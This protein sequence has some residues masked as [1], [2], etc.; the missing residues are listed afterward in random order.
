MPASK[1]NCNFLISRNIY[2]QRAL[3]SLQKPEN[4]IY[5]LISSKIKQCSSNHTSSLSPA[6]NLMRERDRAA[7]PSS[8]AGA[9]HARVG[10]KFT[11]KFSKHGCCVCFLCFQILPYPVWFQLHRFPARARGPES[12][13]SPA[14]IHRDANSLQN[15]ISKAAPQKKRGGKKKK[16][17]E[18][19]K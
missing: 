15:F 11:G 16:K 4:D 19:N 8:P 7:R 1:I 18:K 12:R 2:R 5:T 17:R 3:I 9:R 14:T 6:S 10:L 13:S